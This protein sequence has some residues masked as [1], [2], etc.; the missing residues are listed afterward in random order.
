VNKTS[1]LPL[2][3]SNIVFLFAL[4]NTAKVFAAPK[5]PQKPDAIK[6]RKE[7]AESMIQFL[8][9][10]L[11]CDGDGE[12][13]VLEMGSRLCGGP[14]K[15]LVVSNKNTNLKAIKQKIAEYS[16]AEKELNLTGVSGD[17]SPSPV[18]P[19]PRCVKNQCV[20]NKK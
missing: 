4:T 8:N 20:E 10:K 7:L 16:A 19:Q 11:D 3:L 9:K 14:S 5:E 13:D 1:R 17:C 15:Y 2:L 6:E 18:L 12:C